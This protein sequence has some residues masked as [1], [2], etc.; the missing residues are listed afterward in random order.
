MLEMGFGEWPRAFPFKVCHRNITNKAVVDLTIWGNVSTSERSPN[1]V[2]CLSSNDVITCGGSHC[3]LSVDRIAIIFFIA[4][5]SKRATRTFIDK[6]I[7]FRRDWH[8]I[9]WNELERIRSESISNSEFFLLNAETDHWILRD[10]AAV[11]MGQIQRCVKVVIHVLISVKRCHVRV[12]TSSG[13]ACLFWSIALSL[14]MCTH[15]ICF[16]AFGCSTR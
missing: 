12:N 14:V 16:I 10:E 5:F 1:R 7:H 9:P 3:S 15:T 2:I 11:C 8:K 6:K 13:S 4:Q